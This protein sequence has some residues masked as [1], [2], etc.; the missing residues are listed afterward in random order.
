MAHGRMKK[1]NALKKP[2]KNP[3]TNA[4]ANRFNWQILRSIYIDFYAVLVP[5]ID[6]ACG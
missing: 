5:Q 6:G 2:I 1:S 4:A 3:L